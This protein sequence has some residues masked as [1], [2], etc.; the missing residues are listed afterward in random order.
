MSAQLFLLL[1]QSIGYQ[2]RAT[3]DFLCRGGGLGKED[4]K[5]DYRAKGKQEKEQ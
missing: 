5:N 3:N 1:S 2:P 4:W